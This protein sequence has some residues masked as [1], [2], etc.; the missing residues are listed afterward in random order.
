MDSGLE[1]PGYP[2]M[3]DFHIYND[4]VQFDREGHYK[5]R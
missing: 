5:R 4:L 2:A 3:F 1:R